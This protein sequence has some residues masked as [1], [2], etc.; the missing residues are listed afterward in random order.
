MWCVWEDLAALVVEWRRK[1][2]YLQRCTLGLHNTATGSGL[3]HGLRFVA[4]LSCLYH[5]VP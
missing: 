4:D 2:A 5:K 1:Q 3:S